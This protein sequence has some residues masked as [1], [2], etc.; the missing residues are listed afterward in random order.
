MR[1]VLSLPAEF[2]LRR[3]DVTGSKFDVTMVFRLV[4][5]C[6]F[7]DACADV[8]DGVVRASDV[9]A[10]ASSDRRCFVP[11]QLMLSSASESWSAQNESH[12]V[13]ST[14]D[15]VTCV[16]VDV[17]CN[18][19]DAMLLCNVLCFGVKALCTNGFKV[20]NTSLCLGGGSVAC[21]AL[22]GLT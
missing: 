15:D 18:L 21:S 3:D 10:A 2:V 4:I 7:V 22:T 16:K 14:C 5:L 12:H 11:T 13:S 6:E 17:S 9:T 19:D 8:A 1:S 20:L